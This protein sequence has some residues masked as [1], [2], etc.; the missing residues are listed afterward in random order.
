MQEIESDLSYW[1]Q[2]YAITNKVNYII[3]EKIQSDAQ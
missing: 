3:L 1:K 2:I